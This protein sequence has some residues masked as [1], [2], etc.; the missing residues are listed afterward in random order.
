[1]YD[2]NGT[3]DGWYK[4]L[5]NDWKK[6]STGGAKPPRW[7]D[8][9]LKRDLVVC[10]EEAWTKLYLREAFDKCVTEVNA[11][12]KQEGKERKLVVVTEEPTKED[13]YFKASICF[14]T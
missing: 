10:V 5:H 2:C 6:T 9:P 11:K 13:G 12:L 3:S 7:A 14:R 4:A 8:I 1:M